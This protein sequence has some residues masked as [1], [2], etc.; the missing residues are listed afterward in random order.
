M[1]ETF[2]I[3]E[4]IYCILK[5]I[6]IADTIKIIKLVYLADKY[7]LVRYGRTITKDDYYAMEYGPV[8]STVK[9]VLNF[10]S[11]SLSTAEYK[12]A[13]HLLDKID[14]VTF[15]V[16]EVVKD[17][18]LNMLSET[19]KEAIDFVVEKFGNVSQWELSEY[20]HKYPEWYKHESLFKNKRT[21]RERVETD[22][23]LSLLEND[24][25]AMPEVHVNVSKEIIL[26]RHD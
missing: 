3:I 5:K 16:N 12:Y 20:T 14:N 9:D 1:I 17:V 8:G 26:G 7:H 19:D 11:I 25:L 23:L 13:S 15:K 21:R 22:E 4:T 18:E 24:P 6:K 2:K 10:N